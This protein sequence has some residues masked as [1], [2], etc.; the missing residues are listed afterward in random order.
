MRR[1]AKLQQPV[2]PEFA[3]FGAVFESTKLY[4]YMGVYLVS[5]ACIYASIKGSLAIMKTPGLMA[6]LHQAFVVLS[7]WI[8]SF[9][10]VFP[11]LV[12]LS[13]QP[14]MCIK[15]ASV[16]AALFGLQMLLLYGAL[17]HSSVNMVLA[18]TAAVP[19]LADAAVA[20]ARG[21]GR[22]S[23]LLS[24]QLIPLLAAAA[25][26]LVAEIV[27]DPAKSWLSFLLL[28][29]WSAAKLG[30]TGWRLIKE[31]PSL[32][33][34]LPGGDF[35]AV[36]VWVRRVAEAEE[37]LEA[38]PQA[39]LVHALPALPVL[40]LG[41]VGQEVNEIV[42]HELSVPAVKLMLLSCAAHVGT[43]WCQLLLADRLSGAAKASLRWG[44]LLCAVAFNF[45]EKTEG[46]TVGTA[47]CT[48]GAVA[49]AAGV[50]LQRYGDG[51]AGRRQMRPFEGL[52]AAPL[53][54]EED[55]EDQLGR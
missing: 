12:Q 35:G 45:V 15:G 55:P 4:L 14:W 1:R 6:F 48:V 40:L 46:V 8:A 7:L 43:A 18:W 53:D 10:D 51:G 52:A 42:D 27:L 30:E 13:T 21:R 37:G 50:S 28:L 41:F 16:R 26:A 20:Q 24:P 33:G 32:G 49:A 39:A 5:Q 3:A 19:L 17:L 29:L 2:D 9:Y 23:R 25:L 47:L 31:D 38:A 36:A 11:D 44:A 54:D 34:R 22:S